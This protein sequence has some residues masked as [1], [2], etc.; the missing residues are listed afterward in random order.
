M[1]AD[2]KCFISCLVLFVLQ[3]FFFFHQKNYIF[4]LS[5]V[6]DINGD[7][8]VKLNNV[9]GDKG[10]DDVCYLLLMRVWMK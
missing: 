6:K 7:R 5:V 9:V 1:Q 8:R 10:V 2:Q 4:G 3:F